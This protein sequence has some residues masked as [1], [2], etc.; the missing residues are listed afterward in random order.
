MKSFIAALLAALVAADN[1]AE[2][3]ADCITTAKL[4]AKFIQ[5]QLDDQKIKVVK[6][7]KDEANKD[8]AWTSQQTQTFDAVMGGIRSA[9]TAAE[10]NDQVLDAAV[11][12][13]EQISWT[14]SNDK[15]V[16]PESLVGWPAHTSAAGKTFEVECDSSK[17]ATDINETFNLINAKKIVSGTALKDSADKTHATISAVTGWSKQGG[18]SDAGIDYKLALDVTSAESWNLKSPVVTAVFANTGDDTT[19]EVNEFKIAN[20]AA[21]ETIILVYNSQ[22]L[23]GT[24]LKDTV[25]YAPF[26]D[27]QPV[28]VTWSQTGG[29]YNAQSF[30]KPTLGKYTT[31]AGFWTFDHEKTRVTSGFATDKNTRALI[32]V[33]KPSGALGTVTTNIKEGQKIS[34]MV[35]FKA[36]SAS[37]PFDAKSGLVEFMWA[38]EGKGEEPKKDDTT[39]DG[40]KKDEKDFASSM[41]CYGMTFLAAISAL[42][43]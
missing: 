39:G 38:E 43:F 32:V 35:G 37:T 14:D 1:H 33:D 24:A 28:Q 40:G 34:G 12:L 30:Y 9:S 31:K 3:P 13:F 8:V 4:R 17:P 19:V 21:N 6:T 15:A 18:G 11:Q 16:Q 41:A 22:N 42:A 25:G 29:N 36:S 7:T 10:I 20:F 23:A 5:T 27:A 2:I 26:V